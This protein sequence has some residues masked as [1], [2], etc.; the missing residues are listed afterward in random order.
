MTQ[1][2]NPSAEANKK[3]MHDDEVLEADD[4]GTVL[5]QVGKKRTHEQACKLN[6]RS[7][8]SNA[9]VPTKEPI[10]GPREFT[11]EKNSML[12]HEADP[13]NLQP[14]PNPPSVQELSSNQNEAKD[15]SSLAKPVQGNTKGSDPQ[16][17]ETGLRT[18]GS[19][20]VN[21]IDLE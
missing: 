7:S 4:V 1:T 3:A 2:L 13:L 17:T 9:A 21:T 16:Q 15:T 18:T 6:Q 8:H 11:K 20:T 5:G 10:K 19:G 14:S 12:A